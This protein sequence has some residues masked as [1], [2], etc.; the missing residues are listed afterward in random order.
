M[1]E[2]TIEVRTV[3]DRKVEGNSKGIG[4]RRSKIEE[5]VTKATDTSTSPQEGAV[6]PSLHHLTR[7]LRD[8]AE[9]EIPMNSEDAAVLTSPYRYSREVMLSASFPSRIEAMRRS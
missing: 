5:N 8:A 4:Q 9:G 6:A 1:Y 7:H 3:G 2:C